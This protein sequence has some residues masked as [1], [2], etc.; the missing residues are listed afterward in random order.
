LHGG[1]QSAVPWALGAAPLAG[2]GGSGGGGIAGGNT[3]VGSMPGATGMLAR[4]HSM[5]GGATSRLS[6]ETPRMVIPEDSPAEDYSM[7]EDRHAHMMM[8]F[9]G[10]PPGPSLK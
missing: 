10:S 7:P 8:H 3:G 9:V 6:K 4:A 2:S 1:P 5:G